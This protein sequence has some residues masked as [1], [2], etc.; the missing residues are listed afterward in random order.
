M[1]KKS[2]LRS[3]KD[4]PFYLMLLLAFAMIFFSFHPVQQAEASGGILTIILII[5][6]AL[7]DPGPKTEGESS[8]YLPSV[9]EFV[10]VLEQEAFLS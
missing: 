7:F 8:S 2:V 5:L 10:D 3:V 1:I 9:P 4:A 6:R